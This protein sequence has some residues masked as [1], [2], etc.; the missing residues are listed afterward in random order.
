MLLRL[1]LLIPSSTLSG[2]QFSR[3]NTGTLCFPRCPHVC[4]VPGCSFRRQQVFCRSYAISACPC[5]FL[6]GL[7]DRTT[8]FSLASQAKPLQPMELINS[9]YSEIPALTSKLRCLKVGV[10]SLQLVETDQMLVV[11][12]WMSWVVLHSLWDIVGDKTLKSLLEI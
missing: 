7:S 9:E 5:R 12:F 10:Y 2:V 6:T 3:L 1:W 11:Y 8:H 4:W